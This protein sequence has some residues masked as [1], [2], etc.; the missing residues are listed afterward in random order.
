LSF[1]F[2]FPYENVFAFLIFSMRTTC[3]AHFILLDFLAFLLF[4]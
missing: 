3:P 4:V 1:P 2:I